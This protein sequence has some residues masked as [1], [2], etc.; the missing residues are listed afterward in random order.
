MSV[1]WTDPLLEIGPLVPRGKI[2]YSGMILVDPEDRPP[3]EVG[4]LDRLFLHPQLLLFHPQ[5]YWIDLIMQQHLVGPEDRHPF[6][7]SRDSGDENN[8]VCWFWAI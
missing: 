8:S 3:K 6:Y 5:H 1:L 2:R 7:D 4:P